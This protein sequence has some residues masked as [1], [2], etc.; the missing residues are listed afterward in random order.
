MSWNTWNSQDFPLVDK[1]LPLNAPFRALSRDG[2]FAF[3]LRPSGSIYT[4]LLQ[5]DALFPGAD[6][7][8]AEAPRKRGEETHKRRGLLLKTREEM[9]KNGEQIPQYRLR[10][11]QPPNNCKFS[12]AHSA[13]SSR[14]FINCPHL[15]TRNGTKQKR[16]NRQIKHKT[17]LSAETL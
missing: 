15:S 4:Q 17:E 2:A 7:N 16:D 8:A 1:N 10:F 13:T 3:S 12:S 11:V 14:F 5:N 9:N 6:T